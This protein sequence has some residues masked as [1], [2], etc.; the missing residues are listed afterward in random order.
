MFSFLSGRLFREFTG[1]F[2]ANSVKLSCTG[3]AGQCLATAL[4][5]LEDDVS[6]CKNQENNR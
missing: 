1:V 2:N 6:L 3:F 4:N 5:T